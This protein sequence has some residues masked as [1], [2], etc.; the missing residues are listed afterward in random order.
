MKMNIYAI[1]D[2]AAGAYMRPFFMNADDQAK[3]AF[4]D[5]ATDPDHE[6]GKHPTDY[7]LFKLGLFD[8]NSGELHPFNPEKIIA[9]HEAVALSR[10]IKPGSLKLFDQEV[11]ENAD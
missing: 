11:T 1:W 9:A 4:T 5:I 7:T 3:R 6:I 2:R 10:K 8:D